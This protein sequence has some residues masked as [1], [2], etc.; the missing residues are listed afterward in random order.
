M[1][2]WIE[3]IVE[4]FA[5][6]INIDQNKIFDL[7]TTQLYSATKKSFHILTLPY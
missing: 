3:D 4:I 1:V 6:L 5:K 7:S 2:I